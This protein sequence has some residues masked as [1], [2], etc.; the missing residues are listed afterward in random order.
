MILTGY[1]FSKSSIN[2]PFDDYYLLQKDDKKTEEVLF[3]SKGLRVLVKEKRCYYNVEVSYVSNNIIYGEVKEIIN[4]RWFG[5]S[6]GTK[7]AFSYG[8]IIEV[9]G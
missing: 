3:V 1:L 9:L 8:D 6:I 4:G 5:C 2:Y 7:V